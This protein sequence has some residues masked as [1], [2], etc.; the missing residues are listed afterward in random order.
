MRHILFKF[1][2]LAGLA[3]AQAL[4]SP[5]Q[6]RHQQVWRQNA[7]AEKR[8]TVLE[9]SLLVLLILGMWVLP[10]VYA[11]TPWL[12]FADYRLPGWIGWVGAAVFAG[13][14]W[15]RWR[16]HRDLGRNYS[17]TLV[18]WEGHELVTE[19]V[20]RYIRHPIYGALWLWGISQ[21]LLL[22]NWIAGLAGLVVFLPL[23]LLRVPREEALMLE[24]FGEAYR[25]YMG[26]TGRVVPRVWRMR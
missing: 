10:A 9:R 7:M 2:Y 21:P 6:L 17:S 24:H 15:L 18:V 16:A 20:Y 13:G 3:F 1:L 4:R 11:L 8:L 14:L 25:A 12:G 19:G 23:Y 5:Q 22:Q 26:R